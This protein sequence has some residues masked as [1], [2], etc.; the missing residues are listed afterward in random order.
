MNNT[1]IIRVRDIMRT[2]FLEIDGLN[3]VK[4]A[5][6]A[7]K[8]SNNDSIIVKKR[9]ENDEYGILLLS[10]I[11]NNVL[12]KDRAPE[13]V[14]VYEIMKKPV[15]GVSPEMDVRYCARLFDEFGL[16]SAPVIENNLVI[17]IVGYHG[18]VLRGLAEIYG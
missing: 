9:N 15:V 12:A 18:L 6:E 7:M 17:G 8:K 3:T 5:I 13:R 11:A 14:N 1:K 10:D 2:S 16:A 4:E